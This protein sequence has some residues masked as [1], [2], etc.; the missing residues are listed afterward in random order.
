[1]DHGIFNVRK[2]VNVCD[3]TRRY[4][5]TGRESAKKVD[6]G[7]K[8]PCRTQGIKPASAAC[9]SDALPGQLHPVLTDKKEQKDEEL[10]LGF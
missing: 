8:I 10:V 3:R 9:R 2:D 5:D 6:S 1:M 7:R 4:T